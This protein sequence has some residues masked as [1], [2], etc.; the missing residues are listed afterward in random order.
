MAVAETV[1]RTRSGAV[2]GRTDGG[3]TAFKGI[4]YAAPPFGANRFAPPQPA[5]PWDGV[6][7]ALDFGPTVPHPGYSPPYDLLLPDPLIPGED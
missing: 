6:R 3:V 4:P 1:V 5:D 2:R 7:D